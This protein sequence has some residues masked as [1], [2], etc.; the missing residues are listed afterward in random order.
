MQFQ[1]WHSPSANAFTFVPAEPPPALSLIE[2]DARLMWTVEA[3]SWDEAQAK[4]HEFL[5]WEPYVPIDESGL[6]DANSKE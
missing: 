1:L 4:K 2:D 5:G 6:P 3:D